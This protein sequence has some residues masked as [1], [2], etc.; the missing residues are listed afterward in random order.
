MTSRIRARRFLRALTAC[1]TTHAGR[2]WRRRRRGAARAES[3]GT[4]G[5]RRCHRCL[6]ARLSCHRMRCHFST[7]AASHR[8]LPA[9]I[10]TAAAMLAPCCT[11]RRAAPQLAAVRG[12]SSALPAAVRSC[13]HA[14]GAGATQVC[15]H[16]ATL[17][18]RSAAAPPTLRALRGSGAVRVVCSAASG[19]R[20]AVA[21][22]SKVSGCCLSTRALCTRLHAPHTRRVQSAHAVLRRVL[23]ARRAACALRETRVTHHTPALC[24]PARVS[25][26]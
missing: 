3:E 23:S 7:R 19:K 16:A 26:A 1:A 9:R 11:P 12:T 4:C 22:T 20:Y 18:L 2:T 6:F 8:R 21:T 14:T 13:V 15:S 10:C 25:A 24:F 5:R 17:L